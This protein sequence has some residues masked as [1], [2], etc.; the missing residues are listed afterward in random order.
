VKWANSRCVV[1][2]SGTS[3][4]IMFVDKWNPVD[5]E[6]VWGEEENETRWRNEVH[7]SRF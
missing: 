3:V 7:E 1:T 4:V 5:L 2:A 6:Q